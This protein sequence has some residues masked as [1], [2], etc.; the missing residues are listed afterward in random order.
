MSSLDAASLFNVKDL[1]VIITGGGSGVGLM[2][3]K[4]LALN[5]A[6]KVYI[7]GRWKE[8]L[9]DAAQESPYGNIILVIRDITLKDALLS[10]VSYIKQDA[11]YINVLIANS[12][13]LGP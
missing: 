7:I 10:I 3:T 4:A 9:E 8:V 2:M 6:Y 11:G 5:R 1:V 13:T 12:G